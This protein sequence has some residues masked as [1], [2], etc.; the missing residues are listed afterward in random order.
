MVL[1]AHTGHK[2]M[3]LIP[4]LVSWM[5]LGRPMN[6]FVQDGGTPEEL[7]STELIDTQQARLSRGCNV[8]IHRERERACETVNESL[9]WT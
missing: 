2:T 1:G 4:I 8:D 9:K 6:I 3:H 7:R 5:L